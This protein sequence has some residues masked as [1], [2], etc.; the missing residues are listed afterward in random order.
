MTWTTHNKEIVASLQGGEAGV[1]EVDAYWVVRQ[2]VSDLLDRAESMTAE[3]IRVKWVLDDVIDHLYGAKDALFNTA[4]F[5][6]T[7][8]K[9][10]EKIEEIREHVDAMADLLS[11]LEEGGYAKAY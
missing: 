6:R 2:E 9:G 4:V 7:T 10:G 1:L 8:T 3:D 11:R 5:S